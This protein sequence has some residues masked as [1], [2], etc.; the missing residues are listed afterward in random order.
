MYCNSP[1]VV[2]LEKGGNREKGV[3]KKDL[4]NAELG[5]SLFQITLSLFALEQNLISGAKERYKK[6]SEE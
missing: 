5:A 1:A 2:I 4:A 6:K 3:D